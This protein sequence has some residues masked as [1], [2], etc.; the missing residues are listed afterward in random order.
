MYPLYLANQVLSGIILVRIS[1]NQIR[2]PLA[3]GPKHM[4]C[5]PCPKAEPEFINDHKA[6]PEIINDEAKYQSL[7]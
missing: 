3:L 2:G 7:W 4:P 6:E 5:S 1:K